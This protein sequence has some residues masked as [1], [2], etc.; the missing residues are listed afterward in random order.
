MN[1]LS[2]NDKM[3]DRMIGEGALWS[4]PLIAAF[5]A[6]PRH[7]FLERFYQYQSQDNR[8]RE[9]VTRDPGPAELAWVYADRA[10]ITHVYQGDPGDPRSAVACSSSSQPSLMAE[11]LEDLKL[12]P[13]LRV[14]E[15]GTGT[16]YNAA[17]LA[18]VVGPGQVVSVEVDRNVLAEAWDHLRAFGERGV[19]V[20]Q[21]DGRLG[22]A[23]AA[24][25]DR[26]MVTAASDDL[27]PA[28]L[29]QLQPGGLLLAP[30]VLACGLAFL[31]RGSVAEGVFQGRLVRPAFFLGLRGEGEA[32][33]V[34]VAEP[35]TTSR[36]QSRPAPWAEWFAQASPRLR[37]LRFQLALVFFGWLR[38]LGIH[39]RTLPSGRGI[40]GVGDGAALCWL[41][42]RHWHSN[43]AAGRQV[44]WKLW[45]AFLDAGGPWPTEFALRACPQGGLLSR[46]TTAFCR[47]G[48]CCQ[49]VWE[50]VAP[51]ERPSRF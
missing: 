21:A 49:Q 15:I 22:W 7:R 48:R 12:R 26:L 45:R 46:S 28:W 16:G 13:G 5:R 32:G 31:V 30:L 35:P 8:W 43:G 38:G 17:L 39:Y 19:V 51:G 9:V 37:W 14:L 18:H 10:L 4:P 2:A 3:V 29:Q 6:T 25:Y 33:P 20:H 34:E 50:Q 11:M 24:P 27:E 23:E 44:A 47:Q 40:Y 1:P 42:P 41:G 36:L